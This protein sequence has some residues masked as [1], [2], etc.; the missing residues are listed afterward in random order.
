MWPC[1]QTDRHDETISSFMKILLKH[2]KLYACTAEHVTQTPNSKNVCY[3]SVQNLSLI[4]L[5]EAIMSRARK[6][7]ILF[8]RLR[9]S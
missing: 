9:E 8:V 4:L 5:P 1:K 3:L 2:L 7:V 6:I